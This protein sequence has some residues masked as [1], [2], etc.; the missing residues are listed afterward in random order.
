MCVDRRG[1]GAA[2]GVAV[3]GLLASAC[4]SSGSSPGQSGAGGTS[5]GDGGMGAD[6]A[7]DQ[8]TG[9]DADGALPR[10]F[11]CP[12]YQ[13]T[14]GLAGWVSINVILPSGTS[15]G[16]TS[17][18]QTCQIG[19]SDWSVMAAGTERDGVDQTTM[20][21]K[22]NGTYHG[23]GYYAGSL[24][25]GISGS[26]SHDDLGPQVYASVSTSDC[27][28]C[29]NEDGRSGVVKCWDLEATVGTGA[30]F[31]Y[32][33]SGQFTCPNAMPKPADQ[34]TVPP[35]M[36]GVGGIPPGAVVCH[37]LDKLNCPG[38]VDYDTCV[39]NSDH[40][41]LVG[42]CYGPWETWL[43]CVNMQSPA[44]YRCGRN[45]Q[46]LEMISGACAAELAAVRTCRDAA[47]VLASPECDALCAKAQTQCNTPCDRPTWCEPY[48]THCA[49][50]KLAWL[51]C[52]VQGSAV[53][54]GT[55]PGTYLVL[56]CTYDDSVC[57]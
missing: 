47:S 20:A 41:V 53:T 9:A 42:Q 7:G 22:I 18:I 54:C 2:A 44:N 34:P 25:Q 1:L 33:D 12:A 40:E 51:R 38:R 28:L 24:A 37:Y 21:F 57:M 19:A 26:F 11:W 56:G 4:S 50:A 55:T 36:S 23:P 43:T 27:D 10:P 46:D 32:I 39:K 17:P 35:Q 6:A 3:F 30:A 48:G 15:G 45:G 13:E 31:A 49:A 16:M 5:G 14:S 8:R 29:I 52:A